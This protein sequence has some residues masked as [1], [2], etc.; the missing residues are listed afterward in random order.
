[1]S[2]L[3]VNTMIKDSIKN[4]VGGNASPK[5]K[6]AVGASPRAG[7]ALVELRSF[8]KPLG[9]VATFGGSPLAANVRSGAVFEFL[10]GCIRPPLTCMASKMRDRQLFGGNEALC[11]CCDGICVN[12]LPWFCRMA[13]FLCFQRMVLTKVERELLDSPL[14]PRT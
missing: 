12:L 1:M 13:P 2:G 6:P 3:V 11:A 14:K 5:A 7:L 9:R 10:V 8:D 4:D